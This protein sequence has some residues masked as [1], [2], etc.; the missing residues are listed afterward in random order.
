VR[1]ERANDAQQ[2]RVNG[3]LGR[4]PAPILVYLDA[5]DPP[6]TNPEVDTSLMEF[7]ACALVNDPEAL[8][9]PSSR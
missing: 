7:V 9:K 1:A 8:V 6:N 3:S 2:R 5:T 4:S